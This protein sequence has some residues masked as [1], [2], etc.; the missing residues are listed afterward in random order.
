[1]PKVTPMKSPAERNAEADARVRAEAV[2]SEIAATHPQLAS[3]LTDIIEIALMQ[4]FDRGTMFG[5]DEAQRVMRE[6]LR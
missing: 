1:M 3:A 5:L 6:T 2:T 4:W